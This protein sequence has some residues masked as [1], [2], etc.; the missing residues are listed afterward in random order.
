MSSDRQDSTPLTND[1][2]VEQPLSSPQST[3]ECEVQRLNLGRSSSPA[4]R[5]VSERDGD[6]GDESYGGELDGTGRVK[7]PKSELVSPMPSRHKPIPSI[8]LN[9]QSMPDDDDDDMLEVVQ[10]VPL[11]SQQPAESV[12]GHGQG[13][14]VPSLD[15]QVRQ[16]TE[17]AKKPAKEGDKGYAVAQAWLDRV[18]SR[19]SDGLHG[20]FTK[21]LREG[22]I[23]PVDNSS[24]VANGKNDEHYVL[25]PRRG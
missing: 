17:I 14:A 23:G 7:S 15:E 19:T 10:S 12:I 2:E 18:H 21:E 16:I 1:G 24:I 3:A 25:C 5:T 22:E 9:A 11:P 6:D 20:G 13:A 4:K 8:E